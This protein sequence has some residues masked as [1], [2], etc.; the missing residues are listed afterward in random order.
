MRGD[1]SNTPSRNRSASKLN[2]HNSGTE[3]NLPRSGVIMDS[4]YFQNNMIQSECNSNYSRAVPPK[5]L[6]EA[7]T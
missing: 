6:C 5:I 1:T 7:S 2:H 3:I 4:P